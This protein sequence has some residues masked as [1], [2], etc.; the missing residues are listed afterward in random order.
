MSIDKPLT[1]WLSLVSLPCKASEWASPAFFIPKKDGH[2]RKI[3]DLCSLNKTIICKQYPLPII[4]DMLDCISSYKFFT[5]ID[6]SMQYYTFELDEPSQELCVIVM[7]FG[8]YKYKHLPIGLKCAPH[9]ALQ[10]I[11]EV[12]RNVKDTSAYLDNIGTF[13]F[14]WEH[15]ILLLDKILH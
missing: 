3:K 2:I 14:T 4:T 12:L 7:P 11:E 10:V 8:K 13:S 15:P 1:T 5:Q 6:I 9:F